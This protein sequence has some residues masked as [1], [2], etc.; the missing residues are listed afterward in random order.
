MPQTM[1]VVAKTKGLELKAQADQAE[2][3]IYGD[4]VTDKWFD[5]DVSAASFVKDLKETEA[6][7]LDVFINSGGGSVFDGVTI[8]NALKRHSAHV[9]VHIDGL[10]ASIASVIAMAGDTVSIAENAML[11]IHDPWTVTMGNTSALRKTADNLDTV[12]DSMLSSYKRSNLSE[13]ELMAAMEVETWYSGPEAVEHGFADEVTG[14]ID[15]AASV[16]VPGDRF[17]HTPE[18][19]LLQEGTPMPAACLLYTSPSPRDS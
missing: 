18:Q 7:Q 8:Y 14:A 19:Y 5:E 6:S 11:M 16:K 15:I 2:L 13:E 12:R 10:A 3:Y 17:A 1:R 4:I 9:N